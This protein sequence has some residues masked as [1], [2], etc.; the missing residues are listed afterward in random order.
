MLE[1]RL[2]SKKE[3]KEKSKGDRKREE[4]RRGVIK[5]GGAI[6]RSRDNAHA[7][8]RRILRQPVN[9]PC[10]VPCNAPA[11]LYAAFHDTYGGKPATLQYDQLPDRD[12]K[13]IIQ[14]VRERTNSSYPAY[15]ISPHL[16]YVSAS[17]FYSRRFS[18]RSNRL[19]Q[20]VYGY[21]RPHSNS[22]CVIGLCS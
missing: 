21:Q 13:F 17:R 4:E 1:R 9:V 6:T 11:T 15:R 2:I 20:H 8:S 10:T 7:T 12:N 5:V 14:L 16:L 3:I 22:F 18:A 19:Y